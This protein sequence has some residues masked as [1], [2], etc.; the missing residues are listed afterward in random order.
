MKSTKIFR[1]LLGGC[2]L[3][4]GLSGCVQTV[5]RPTIRLPQSTGGKTPIITPGSEQ[6][7]PVSTGRAIDNAMRA[8]ARDLI[9]SAPP[10]ISKKRIAVLPMRDLSGNAGTLAA[11]ANDAFRVELFR[12]SRLQF[13]ADIDMRRA[14]KELG[15]EATLRANYQLDPSVLSSIRKLLSAELIVD[16]RITD[17]FTEL[18]VTAEIIDIATGRLIVPATQLLS[19]SILGGAA[20]SP[21]IENQVGRVLAAGDDW[22]QTRLDSVRLDSDRLVRAKF[23]FFNRSRV[24][25]RLALIDP[26]RRAYLVD[27]AGVAASYFG[28]E[29]LDPA[30]VIVIRPDTRHEIALLF[31]SSQAPSGLMTMRT[32]WLARGTPRGEQEFVVRDLIVSR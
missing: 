29:G 24:A 10:E 30:G 5:D 1:V 14:I 19:K 31:S 21:E 23:S 15:I 3:L 2:C 4:L 11:T 13:V 22:L 8:L 27:G 17:S 16:S 25:V 18:R 32:T 9:E 12:A 7:A 26:Q 20:T 28:A 6:R